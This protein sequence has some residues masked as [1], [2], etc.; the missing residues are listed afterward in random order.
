M[1]ITVTV[2]YAINFVFIQNVLIGL[3]DKKVETDYFYEAFEEDEELK[4][5]IKDDL[6]ESELESQASKA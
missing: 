2:L 4:T 1:W 3:V 5:Q 6:H